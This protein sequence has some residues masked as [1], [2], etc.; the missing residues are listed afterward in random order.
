MNEIWT[1]SYVLLWIIVAVMTFIVVGL[2]RQLGLIQARLGPEAGALI[3]PEGLQRGM[4]AP[5]FD[6]VELITEEQIRLRDFRG[7]RV[8]LVFLSPTCVPCRN[9]APH[10]NQ[11]Y[12]QH[13]KHVELLALCSGSVD[14]CREFARI[15]GLRVPLIA[16]V[17]NFI[18]ALYDVRFTPFAFLLNEN[19]VV[20]IRG[21]VNTPAHLEALLKEEGTLQE[22]K[23][24]QVALMPQ[25][26]G[27]D[28][29]RSKQETHQRK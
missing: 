19:A 28:A 2:L 5:D 17:T 24:W 7:R 15:S 18:G 13:R 10:L 26:N 25:A 22:E 20:L 11:V 16:D 12:S 1:A 29:E 21:V 23:P 8:L 3:T 27:A 4:E 9:L 14:A 6:G